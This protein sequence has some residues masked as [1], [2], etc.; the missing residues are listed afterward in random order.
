MVM[1]ARGGQRDSQHG[2]LC[3]VVCL[4]G[5]KRD[6]KSVRTDVETTFIDTRTRCG[7]GP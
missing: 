7:S 2:Q 1:A 5:R 4:L 3:T 6:G